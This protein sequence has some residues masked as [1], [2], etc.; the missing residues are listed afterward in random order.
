MAMCI[1]I[2]QR[3]GVIACSSNKMVLY[4]CYSSCYGTSCKA[5][6]YWQKLTSHA[7]RIRVLQKTSNGKEHVHS[8]GRRSSVVTSGM[9]STLRSSKLLD[10][11]LWHRCRM[12]WPWSIRMPRWI[13]RNKK[14]TRHCCWFCGEKIE[15]LAAPREFSACS[16][17][18]MSPIPTCYRCLYFYFHCPLMGVARWTTIS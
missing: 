18:P 4:R 8:T 9:P 5:F 16:Y 1:L 13:S 17:V 15:S 10:L 14:K 2:R 3:S 12:F 11:V 6:R 7:C